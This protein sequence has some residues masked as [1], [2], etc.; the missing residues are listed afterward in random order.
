MPFKKTANQADPLLR[1]GVRRF[2]AAFAALAGR[3][4]SE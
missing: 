4:T 2:P 1:S 3:S